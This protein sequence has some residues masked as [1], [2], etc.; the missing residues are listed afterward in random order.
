MDVPLPGDRQ[1]WCDGRFLFSATRKLKDAKRFFR[2]A[3]QRHGLQAQVTING[4]QTNLEAARQCH[5][6]VRL[7][8]RSKAKPLIVRQNQYRNNRIEQDHRRIKRRTRPM[9]GFKSTATATVIL[10]GIELIPMLRKGQQGPDDR[11]FLV[12]QFVPPPRHQQL[13]S[14]AGDQLRNVGKSNMIYE[15]IP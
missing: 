10:D 1:G 7:R 11:P 14:Q 5:G 8:S 12:R 6:E 9:L 15:F 3:Y 2:R 13:P 4:S